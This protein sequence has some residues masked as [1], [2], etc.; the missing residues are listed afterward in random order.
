MST[1]PA[2]LPQSPLVAGY[3]EQRTDAKQ[4]STMST[5]PAKVRR[6]FTAVPTTFEVQ[7]LLTNTE[8]AT[9]ETFYVDTLSE[10]TDSF[11]VP[12]PRTGTT[13]TV[14]YTDAKALAAELAG[15]G[16]QVRVVGPDEVVAFHLDVLNQVAAA[17]G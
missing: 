11:D 2:T 1:W 14:H 10:G 16:P 5:G 9:F 17:H 15:F 7:H 3:S 4:R 13:V 6:R 8:L 12:H